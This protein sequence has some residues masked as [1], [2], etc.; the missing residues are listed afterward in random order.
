MGRGVADRGAR[1][2]RRS[3]GAGWA[4]VGSGAASADRGALRA[5]G[6]TGWQVGAERWPAD[7]RD[8]D[9]HPPDGL[10]AALRLGLSHAGGGGVGLDPPAPL[11]PHRAVGAGAGRVDDQEA[12]P[13]ARAGDGSG[14]DA[15][16]D[17]EGDPRA[18]LPAASG[19]GRLDGGRGRREVSDRRGSGLARSAGAGPRG[20]PA[21][22]ADLREA[23]AGAGP[24]AGVG[25]QAAGNHAHDPPPRARP[26]PTC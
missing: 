15:D 24:L 20:A 26:R 25:P 19:A 5:R 14:A 13:Q 3:G 9:L 4:V 1:A 6:R 7:D 8:G 23:G 22:R 17:L 12:H 16:A 21:R 2:A 11:L 10:E 18:A